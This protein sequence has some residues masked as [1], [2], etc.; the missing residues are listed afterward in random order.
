MRTLFPRCCAG[1]L[2]L[3]MGAVATA[4]E[5]PIPEPA[6]PEPMRLPPAGAVAGAQEAPPPEPATPGPLRLPPPG[7]P[8]SPGGGALEFG[9]ASDPDGA[10]LT[11]TRR[12]DATRG[13]TVLSRAR[14][15]FDPVGSRLAGFRLDA[16]ATLRAGVDTNVY[17]VTDGPSDAFALGE[18]DASLRSDWSRHALEVAGAVRHRQY[19]TET[20]RD[21]TTYGIEAQGELDI[22][23][24]ARLSGE[25]SHER[26]AR[27]QLS[28]EE[29]AL[30]LR[31]VRFDETSAR[32]QG[33]YESGR[34]VL[35]ANGGY[36]HVDYEPTANLNGVVQSLRDRDYDSYTAGAQAGYRFSG[37]AVA[38]VSA[39]QEWRRHPFDASPRRD[40]DVLELLAGLES[41]IT[42]LLFG[43]VALGYLRTNFSDPAVSSRN[44]FAIDTRLDYLLTELTTVHLTARR[45]M[46]DAALLVAPA[47]L[48]TNV[49]LS[50]DH[51]LLRNVIVSPQVLYESADYVG[52]G[53]SA[54]LFGG[55][56]DARWL[57]NRRLRANVSVHYRSRSTENFSAGRDYDALIGTAGITV[58]L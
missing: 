57:I 38:F 50:A 8:A 30:V 51:E 2:W 10:I 25:I 46:R 29:V 37:G 14:P 23:P 39:S 9:S 7:A 45:T 48:V 18:V 16:G 43:R 4:Q 58:V 53:Q 5:A 27:D 35:S 3:A 12:S 19:A 11:S 13:V 47:T 44:G 20:L 24:R 33:H 55:G 28:A 31:P 34:I 52:T 54:N 36:A 21:L 15:D 22:S 41:E 32:L 1:A 26:D 40:S 6:P 17:R 56:V 49:R 42:P